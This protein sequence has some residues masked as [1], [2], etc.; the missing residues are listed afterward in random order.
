M[1]GLKKVNFDL[2]ATNE[3]IRDRQVLAA[4]KENMGKLKW[5]SVLNSV[6]QVSTFIGGPLLAGSLPFAIKSIFE[7][8]SA[9]ST[10]LTAVAGLAAPATL[11]ILGTMAVAAA[12]IAVAVG[13]NYV[14]SR[15]WQSKTF[16]NFEINAQST[17]N[18]LIKELKANNM[19]L[20]HEKPADG[21]NWVQYE[22]ARRDAAT[23][24]VNTRA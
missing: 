18:H 19:C 3:S 15:I 14:A 12:F 1:F 16:D 4:K 9:G 7:S 6:S 23:Q 5:N 24:L 17:A 20:E 22:N 2:T 13:T 10:F 21:K 11:P 8:M